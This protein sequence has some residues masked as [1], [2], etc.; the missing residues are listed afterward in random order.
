MHEPDDQYLLSDP[1]VAGAFAMKA[2]AN[3]EWG[4]AVVDGELNEVAHLPDV[5][6]VLATDEWKTPAR[7]SAVSIHRFGTRSELAA[8]RLEDPQSYHAAP[9]ERLALLMSRTPRLVGNPARPALHWLHGRPWLT[10]WVRPSGSG[11]VSLVRQMEIAWIDASSV[12]QPALVC[13]VSGSSGSGFGPINGGPSGIAVED[14]ARF[15]HWQR[16]YLLEWPSQQAQTTAWQFE[17]SGACSASAK[18]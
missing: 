9:G 1:L 16:V 10:L 11:K 13:A 14:Q 2:D 6:E 18:L 8:R 5:G 17:P 15:D 12:D 4:L 3:D 7:A